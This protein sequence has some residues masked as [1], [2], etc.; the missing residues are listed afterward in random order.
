MKKIKKKLLGNV[1]EQDDE[2]SA[3]K[4]DLNHNL[5]LLNEESAKG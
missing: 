2:I 3:I 5:E 4:F 1:N